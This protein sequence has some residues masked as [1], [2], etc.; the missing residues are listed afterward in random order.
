MHTWVLF[1]LSALP[2]PDPTS[3]STPRDAIERPSLDEEDRRLVRD[4]RWLRP[5]LSP[6]LVDRYP[7]SD[8]RAPRREQPP[9][10]TGVDLRM[11]VA[12]DGKV[13]DAFL[14]RFE[15]RVAGVE[16]CVLDVARRWFFWPSFRATK[17]RVRLA[18]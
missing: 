1:L 7:P 11:V 9:A 8:V 13:K 6:D 14:I 5:P 16:T 15:P 18:F 3:G 12:A 10:G 4:L 2:R 17:L